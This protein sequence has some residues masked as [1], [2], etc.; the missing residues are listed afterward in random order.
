MRHS[1][2]KIAKLLTKKSLLAR[3]PAWQL[4]GWRYTTTVPR[5]WREL[6]RIACSWNDKLAVKRKNGGK[7]M[8]QESR[9]YYSYATCAVWHHTT[10][11]SRTSISKQNPLV[12]TCT[13]GRWA[14]WAVLA[15]LLSHNYRKSVYNRSCSVPQGEL[16]APRWLTL[17][18]WNLLY[19]MPID[20]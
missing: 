14:A 3:S 17:R 11:V 4:R 9:R 2:P 13:G 15:S 1:R 7:I 10:V 16:V 18:C 19:S 12:K 8:N 5:D 6:F 20:R